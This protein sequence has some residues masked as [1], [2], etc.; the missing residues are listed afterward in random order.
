MEKLL[1]LSDRH[2]ARHLFRSSHLNTDEGVIPETSVLTVFQALQKHYLLVNV[3]YLSATQQNPLFIGIW[4][5]IIDVT[6]R[7]SPYIIS[8]KRK[9]CLNTA[10]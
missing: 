1:E 7:K 10:A 6:V 5:S 4:S 9:K 8:L 3:T 2:T